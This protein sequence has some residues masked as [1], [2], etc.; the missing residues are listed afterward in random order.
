MSLDTEFERIAEAAS[1]GVAGGGLVNEA[2]ND[3][4]VAAY[5]PPDT[6]VNVLATWAEGVAEPAG[7]RPQAT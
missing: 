7:E 5:R 6:P 1:R 4:A 2:A 3:P